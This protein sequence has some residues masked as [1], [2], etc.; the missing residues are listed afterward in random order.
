MYFKIP[1]PEAAATRW[2]AAASFDESNGARQIAQ[3]A[4]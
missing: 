3:I 1:T 2:M 4:Q